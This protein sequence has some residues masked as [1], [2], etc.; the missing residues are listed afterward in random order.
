MTLEAYPDLTPLISTPPSYQ[1]L[2]EN[3]LVARWEW[4]DR[5]YGVVWNSRGACWRWL[6]QTLIFVSLVRNVVLINSPDGINVYTVRSRSGEFDRIIM[7]GV[8][9]W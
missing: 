7:V 8:G 4:V 2:Q 5:T 1:V 3:T 6:F 9:G